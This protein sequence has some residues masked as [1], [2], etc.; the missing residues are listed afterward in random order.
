MLSKCAR[1]PPPRRWAGI[2]RASILQKESMARLLKSV[3]VAVA[4]GTLITSCNRIPDNTPHT[5]SH[6]STPSNIARP[7][8]LPENWLG[9][10]RGPEGTSLLLSKTSPNRYEISIRSL[11]GVATYPGVSDQG[12]ITFIRAGQ[13]ERIRAGSGRD[14]GMKWLLDKNSCLVIR[15]GE[16][17]CKS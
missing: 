12:E 7:S 4:G 9:L 14:T 15:P 16:G 8:S 11:D 1:S 13:S 2:F 3:V 17:F 5:Q 10:W 6:L